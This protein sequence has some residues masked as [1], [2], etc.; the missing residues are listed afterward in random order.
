MVNNKYFADADMISQIELGDH[1][2]LFYRTN[3]E[4]LNIVIPFIAIGL[5]RNEQC[6][7]ITEDNI[8][9]DIYRKLQEFGVDVVKAQ[10]K[11]ALSVVTKH[12]TYLR[13][14]VFQPE[15]MIVELCEA[16]DSAVN[17]GF[18]GLRAAGELSW[19][20]DLPSALALMITY[21]EALEER[22]YSKFAALCQYDESRFP[23]HLVERMKQLHPVVVCGGKVL[24]RPSTRGLNA[25]V[26]GQLKT[27]H[28]GSH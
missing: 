22:F 8:T 17:A 14:G 19:A 18:T 21:E 11:G 1:A 26:T 6:L 25:V 12:E 13:H 2:A 15:K 23:T 10:E 28:V 24:R 20:L 16:V 4:R 27:S 7:Y 9:T 5:E 3:A